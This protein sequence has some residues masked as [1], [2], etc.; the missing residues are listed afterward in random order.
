MPKPAM[1]DPKDIP[2]DDLVECVRTLQ[3]TLW[4]QGTLETEDGW[5]PDTLASVE[6]ILHDAGLAPGE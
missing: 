1:K 4:P 5:T 2:Y 6:G 3:A